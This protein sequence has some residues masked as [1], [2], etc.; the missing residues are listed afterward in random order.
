MRRNGGWDV[1]KLPGDGLARSG[2][3]VRFLGA[4]EAVSPWGSSLPAPRQDSTWDLPARARRG[5]GPAEGGRAAGA[6]LLPTRRPLLRYVLGA[7]ALE[8]SGA[9][10]ISGQMFTQGPR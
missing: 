6:R 10:R 9:P 7:L 1:V 8:V 4:A 2:H 5:F 3:G